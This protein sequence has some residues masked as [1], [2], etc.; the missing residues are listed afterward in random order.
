MGMGR[1]TYDID[2]LSSIL[3]LCLGLFGVFLLLTI[4]SSLF[5]SQILFLALGF[6]LLWVV[7]RVHVAILWWLAPAA[8]VISI[9][10]LIA[11]YFFPEIRGSARWIVIGGFQIQPSELVKPLML[12][13]TARFIATHPPRVMKYLPMHIVLFLVP[14]LLIFKQP[15]FGTSLVYASMWFAMMLAGGLRLSL[16]AIGGVVGFFLG[17][18]VWNALAAYQKSRVIT[19]LNPAL[20]PQG[21][22]YNAIQAMIAVGSGQLFGRG[23]GRG[24]QSHL[25]FLPEFHTD[26]IFATLIEELGFVGGFVLFLLYGLLLWRILSPLVKGKISH[27]FPYVFSIGVFA[28]ILSQVFINAGMNM[29]LIPITGITLPLVSY[30]G[31]SLLSISITFGLLWAVLQ[32]DIE[33]RSVA[34]RR[35]N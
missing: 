2:W 31:S 18:V 5:R 8:Y 13:A 34:I 25:R 10:L 35:R 27:I 26:F 11:T 14:F 29:G 16:V 30:G 12:L 4:D 19:F 21:A 3:L 1:R 9:L 17:P 32:T 6:L 20:D 28:M 7:S 23:L 24:T 33:D 15:D 22:G